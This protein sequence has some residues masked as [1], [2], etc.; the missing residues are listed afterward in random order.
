[1]EDQEAV[2]LAEAPEEAS[3]ALAAAD[4]EAV[5]LEEDREDLTDIGT[6]TI[7]TDREY[8]FSDLAITVEEASLEALPRF[9]YLYLFSEW[10]SSASF[11]IPWE[12]S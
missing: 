1:M 12:A 11:S 8:G 9:L 5:A 7:I 3:A 10:S 2:D 4:L 6:I